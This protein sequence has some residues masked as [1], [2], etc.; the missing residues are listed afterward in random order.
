MVY[1]DNAATTGKKPL[2]VVRAVQQ[3]LQLYSANPGRGGHAASLKAGEL[4]Y[5]A[6]KKTADFFGAGAAE[7]VVFTASC[8]AALNMAIKGNLMPGDRVVLS[9]LEHNAVARPIYALQKMGV[10]AEVAEVIFGDSDATLRSF[11]RCISKNTKMVVCT[12]SSNVTGEILP[13]AALGE[14]CRENGILF[15]VDAAQTAG[16]LPLNMQKQHIDY[17]C[18]APH[19]GLYA[20]MGVGV[21]IASKPPKNTLIEGGTGVASALPV[22]PAELPERLEAGTLNVPGIAGVLAGLN[23]VFSLGQNRL[24]NYEMELLRQIYNGIRR[25]PGIRLYT[26]LPETQKFTPVLSFN[27]AGQNSNAV[28]ESLNTAGFCVRGGLHCAPGTHKR[29]GTL[30]TGTVRISPAGFN[31]GAEAEKLVFAVERLVKNKA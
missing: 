22:Q 27:I 10:E 26:P 5:T 23:Y 15:V 4:V 3:A 13:I 14:V 8:T 11:K 6:R 16:L 21:L 19:K 30:E 28:A 18:V 31:T 12:H 24:Y 20:P 29:L 9:S 25:L 7:Q 2:Q 1:L 17:L